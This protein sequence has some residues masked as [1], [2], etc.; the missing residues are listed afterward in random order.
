MDAVSVQLETFGLQHVA[1]QERALR[2]IV[3]GPVIP[4]PVA[5]LMQYVEL[6]QLDIRDRAFGTRQVQQNPLTS[7]ADVAEVD[8]PARRMIVANVARLLNDA[9]FTQ[10]SAELQTVFAALASLE[11]T[12]P[13]AANGNPALEK[14]IPRAQ[15]LADLGRAGQEALIIINQNPAL[16]PDWLATKLAL[17]DRAAKPTSTLKITWLPS[18]RTLIYMAAYRSSYDPMTQ[19]DWRERV[20][21]D[22]TAKQPVKE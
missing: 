11:Q 15:D 21:A 22:A 6:Y 1:A 8:T 12:Y 10:G 3:G 17:L 9:N 16:A 18:F 19:K 13:P 2:Q 7:L 20:V 4:A 5:T 14:A